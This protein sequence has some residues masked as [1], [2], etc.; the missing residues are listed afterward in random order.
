MYSR[1]WPLPNSLDVAAADMFL[2]SRNAISNDFA[3]SLAPSAP[4]SHLAYGA[5]ATREEL[6]L[7]RIQQ[8]RMEEDI[9]QL[10]KGEE[11]I[12]K[13]EEQQIQALARHELESLRGTQAPASIS[14]PIRLS[15]PQMPTQ[16][17]AVIEI[18][19]SSDDEKLR[20]PFDNRKRPSMITTSS[21][22]KKRPKISDTSLQQSDMLSLYPHE[23][24]ETFRKSEK[25]RMQDTLQ[26][27]IFIATGFR[28]ETAPVN[29]PYPPLE[30]HLSITQAHTFA[31]QMARKEIEELSHVVD[32]TIGQCSKNVQLRDKRQN[33]Q[34]QKDD[35]M[36]DALKKEIVMLRKE[37][38]LMSEKLEQDDMKE[39]KKE[40]VNLKTKNKVLSQGVKQVDMILKNPKSQ[41]EATNAILK[42]E[43]KRISNALRRKRKVENNHARAIR[44]MRIVNAKAFHYL[45]ESINLSSDNDR[46]DVKK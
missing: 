29:M 2:A 42:A 35:T 19:D 20:K 16:N 34:Q 40:I 39:L 37:N 27:I 36:V 18:Q 7:R 30:M 8:E 21:E 23:L 32:V 43:N 12:K 14:A 28:P 3:A 25:A 15:E 5:G 38:K 11:R 44:D 45:R 4:T 41:V 17:D 1:T 33:I 31:Q 26:S 46:K 22:S 6:F 9:Y 13:L 24:V 10:R